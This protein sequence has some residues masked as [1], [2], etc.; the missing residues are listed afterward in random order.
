MSSLLATHPVNYTVL[1]KCL[2]V[3]LLKQTCSCATNA[4]TV[5]TRIDSSCTCL[6]IYDVITKYMAMILRNWKLICT[7]KSLLP[8][9]RLCPLQ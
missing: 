7:V 9:V 2:P 4:A 3:R 8:E 5:E 6:I 1:H